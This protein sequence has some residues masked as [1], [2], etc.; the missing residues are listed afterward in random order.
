MR[1]R[2]VVPGYRHGR[3][4]I[5]CESTEER[6]LALILDSMAYLAFQE[7]PAMIDFIW[8][9]ER[10]IHYPDFAIWSPQGLHFVECKRDDEGQSLGMRAR[11][12]HLTDILGEVRIGYRLLT[13]GEL[14]RTFLIQNAKTLRAARNAS[15]SPSDDRKMRIVISKG[16]CVI[17]DLMAKINPSRNR[18]IEVVQGIYSA[19]YA[20]ALSFNWNLL[21]D[22]NSIVDLGDTEARFPW[23]L[24]H[25][26]KT[27]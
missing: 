15:L 13:R 3:R 12:E 19:I 8:R 14:D 27:S 11:T 4:E 20:G 16:P 23:P 21:L 1:R 2:F 22:R 25:Y 26:A 6:D 5:H 18:S 7:Q 9:G 10:H 17:S 24:H